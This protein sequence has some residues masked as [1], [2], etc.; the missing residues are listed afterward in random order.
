[1]LPVLEARK[2]RKCTHRHTH[3]KKIA[4]YYALH[5]AN[6]MFRSQYADA[7]LQ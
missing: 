4:M 7:H 1:M 3:T 2:R 6:Q 5:Y